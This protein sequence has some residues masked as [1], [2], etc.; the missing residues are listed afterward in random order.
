MHMRMWGLGAALMLGLLTGCARGPEDTPLEIEI[1]QVIRDQIRLRRGKATAPKP[2]VLT[3]A[4]LETI[5]EPHIEVEIEEVKLRDYLTLQVARQ[6]DVPGRIELWRSVDNISFGFRDG[7]LISTRGLRGTLLSAAVP[8]DGQG[9]MGP[10][11]G[12]LRRYE[13]AGDDNASY[14]VQLACE[15]RDLGAEPLEIVGLIYPTQ[16]LQEYCRGAQGGVILND[17]WVDRRDGRLWQSRQWAGP[18]VGYIRVRQV[19]I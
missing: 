1:G 19:V 3:R 7:M 10:A 5:A 17:Y 13:F 2:P 11:S 15:L 16:H 12:G 14:R 8:A 6:D 18:E 9:A 4:L